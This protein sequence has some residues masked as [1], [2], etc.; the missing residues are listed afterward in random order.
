MLRA[1]PHRLNR[2]PHITILGKKVPARRLE[3]GSLNT[4]CVVDEFGSAGLA[5]LDHA[6]PDLVAIALD[7]RV[8]S[9]KLMR[10]LREESRMDAAEDDAR[11]ALTG[12]VSYFVAAQG[13][14]GMDSD[15][16]HI[17]GLDGFRIELRQ[18]FVDND[19]IA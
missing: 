8:S 6:G 2:C 18:G 10:F 1:A 4:A 14:A 3:G 5:V 17:A 9:A 19:R 15:A 11:P 16:D 13:V 12:Q 7:H